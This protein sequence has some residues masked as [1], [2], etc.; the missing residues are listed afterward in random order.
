MDAGKGAAGGRRE[1]TFGDRVRICR[2]RLQ[3]AHRELVRRVLEQTDLR[4]VLPTKGTPVIGRG[5][6]PVRPTG[7][8]H[9]HDQ[10]HLFWRVAG[11]IVVFSDL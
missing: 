5:P 1:R 2:A 6:W 10:V 4:E 3:E 11:A 7:R 9:C 8:V